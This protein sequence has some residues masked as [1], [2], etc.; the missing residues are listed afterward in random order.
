MRMLLIMI[1]SV[2]V[3]ACPVFA[4]QA[5]PPAPQPQAGWD[6][7]ETLPV[8]TS[9]RL[10]TTR[11]RLSCS[12]HGADADTLACGS[13]SFRRT[14]VKTIQ[15]PHRLRSTLVAGVI[16]TAA[17]AVTG[18]AAAGS[19]Q[20]STNTFCLNFVSRADIAAVGAGIGAIV[21][22]PIGYF[23]DFTRST[24]YKAR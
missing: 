24:V 1:G 16:G 11:A 10:K 7:V 14:E 15:R 13:G 4:Q 21:A 23:T 19:H 8:G 9:L 18:Y 5:L 12:F 20:C 22:L 6:S 2:V 3:C 17:G